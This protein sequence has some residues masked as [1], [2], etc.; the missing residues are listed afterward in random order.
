VRAPADFPYLHCLPRPAGI[1]KNLFDKGG[2]TQPYF[3]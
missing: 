3:P 1:K 2:T